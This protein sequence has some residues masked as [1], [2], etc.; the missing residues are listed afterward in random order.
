[1]N[2]RHKT[3]LLE[4]QSNNYYLQDS[5]IT[6]EVVRETTT[7]PRIFAYSQLSPHNIDY[8]ER[9]LCI[10]ETQQTPPLPNN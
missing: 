10:W 7:K 6:A 8:K 9:W 1:M 2:E 4:H 3:S 5:S